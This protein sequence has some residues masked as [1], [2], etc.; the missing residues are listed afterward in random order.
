ML[1]FIACVECPT[2]KVVTFPDTGLLGTPVS[3]AKQVG[4]GIEEF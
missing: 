1:A 3:N 4:I 2:L